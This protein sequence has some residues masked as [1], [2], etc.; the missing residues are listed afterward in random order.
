MPALGDYNGVRNIE[1]LIKYLSS[2]IAGPTGR[3]VALISFLI[4]DYT[5]P[6]DPWSFKYTNVML[7]ILT[8]I[9]LAWLAFLLARA[10]GR[11]ITQ[12]RWIAVLTA[13]FWLLHPLQVSTALYVVQRMTILAALFSL[14]ALICYVKGRQQLNQGKLSAYWIMSGGTI[15]F[16]LLAV[17]S[18][19]NAFLLPLFIAII[20]YTAFTTA[21]RRTLPYWR[22]WQLVFISAP[23]AMMIIYF[24]ARWPRTIAS[25]GRRSYTLTERL[26]TEARILVDYLYQLTIPRIHS[27]GLYNDDYVISHSLTEPWTTLPALF[28]IFG[29]I[30]LALYLRK[31]LAAL[32]LAIL[33]FFAGHILE[34]TFI[35]LE[36]YFEHRNYLPSIFLFFALAC[37]LVY[38]AQTR[39]L[40]TLALTTALMLA[41]G[42]STWARAELWGD[43]T[44]LA[45]VWAQ[46]S[47]NSSRSQQ[48]AALALRRIGRTD[49]GLM[50]L[51]KAIQRSPNNAGY[52]LHYIAFACELNI[53]DRQR[54]RAVENLLKKTTYR[55]H[56]Y[57]LLTGLA[58]L[59]RSNT[60]PALEAATIHA[61]IDALADNETARRKAPGFSELFHLKG[62]LYL[63]ERKP[64]EALTQFEK[65]FSI[66]TKDDVA[67]VQA[68]MLASA[69]EEMLALTHLQHAKE[70]LSALG[71]RA[72]DKNPDWENRI[73]ELET[74]ILQ[75][76]Q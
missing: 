19:E 10:I 73:E 29:L 68:G 17:L 25:Y 76:S 39:K 35:A 46:E 6:T 3:P 32:S 11:N 1:T 49:L 31:T 69:G 22:Y 70:R 59:K 9:L 4:D 60:C 48:Q 36:L 23:I 63:I 15:G 64:R 14:A 40:I 56:L 7:H 51:D 37:G 50:V 57:F 52:Q 8:G 16:G 53:V 58:E 47:P 2:G 55:N 65:A 24:A 33:F 67:L 44:K 54:L 34:S 71:A 62:K 28:F 43:L 61:L 66:H 13:A 42:G 30:G 21:Q 75:Y 26:L 72:Y 20:E 41:Y 12:A 27:S 38:L 5:W 74:A 45:L 18:K